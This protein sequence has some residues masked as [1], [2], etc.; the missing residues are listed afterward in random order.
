MPG[1]AYDLPGH[2][3]LGV[4]GGAAVRLQE[5]LDRLG[6]AVQDWSLCH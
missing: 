3:Q 2:I 1:S 5:G 6:Q 4:G